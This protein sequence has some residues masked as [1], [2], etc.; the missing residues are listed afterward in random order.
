VR[1]RT[2]LTLDIALWL[3]GRDQGV[4]CTVPCKE[5]TTDA[6]GRDSSS[7]RVPRSLPSTS[8][9]VRVASGSLPSSSRSLVAPSQRFVPSAPALQESF[10]RA[11]TPVKPA[12]RLCRTHEAA[13]VL[14]CSS[15]MNMRYPQGN[16]PHPWRTR[17]GV[18]RA[19]SDDAHRCNQRERRRPWGK[20]RRPR[21]GVS[22]NPASTRAWVIARGAVR[23]HTAATL[24]D[25]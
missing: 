24:T 16:L 9:S 18:V 2:V 8:R 10:R 19:Y 22:K 3:A 17:N 13:G 21:Q 23:E 20:R 15:R 14:P 25:A 5:L 7:C 1:P 11:Q 4:R 6:R 12:S